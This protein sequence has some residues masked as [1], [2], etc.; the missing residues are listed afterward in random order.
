MCL[1]KRRRAT[2]VARAPSGRTRMKNRRRKGLSDQLSRAQGAA[3]VAGHRHHDQARLRDGQ[4]DDRGRDRGL[5]REPPCAVAGQHR[6]PDQHDPEGL[7]GRMDATDTVGIWARIY[8]FQLG[9]H[10]MGAATA[11]AMSGLDQALWDTQGQGRRL[12]L[13]K[14]WAAP[15]DRAGLC[16]RHLAGLPGAGSRWPTRPNPWSPLATRR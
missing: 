16:R 2:G 15:T 5:G 14:L 11:M 1:G 12:P 9:S 7:R 4:G 13:Y 10:G 8:K 6:P 3:G